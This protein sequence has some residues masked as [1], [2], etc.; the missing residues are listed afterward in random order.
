[1]YLISELLRGSS[2]TMPATPLTA[3]IVQICNRL[4]QGDIAGARRLYEST[5]PMINIMMLYGPVAGKTFLH[6][7]GVIRTPNVRDYLQAWMIMILKRCSCFWTNGKF[8]TAENR[9]RCVWVQR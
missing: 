3:E 2:G 4:W 8:A 5:L 1:M 7:A 6:L 9:V